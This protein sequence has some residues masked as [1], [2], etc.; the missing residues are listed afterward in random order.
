MRGTESKYS[1][2]AITIDFVLM[3]FSGYGKFNFYVLL[4]TGGCL[5]CVIIETMCMS[6]IIPAAQCDLNLT[7][8]QK[9]ILVSIGFLGVITTSHFWG[10]MADYRGRK[11]ILVFCLITSSL[12]TL[13]CSLVPWVW[14][15]I[16]LRF[17]NGA[18]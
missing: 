11:D 12:S 1:L 15:F 3:F 18:L 16:L 5:M 17:M 4:A 7:L 9:G 13:A 6:F 10:F 8:T 14:L 2:Y